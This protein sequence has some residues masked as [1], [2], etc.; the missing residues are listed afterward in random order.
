MIVLVLV[1]G[2]NRFEQTGFRLYPETGLGF[3]VQ[4]KWTVSIPHMNT[5][6][7][8]RQRKEISVKNVVF[9]TIL[10]LYCIVQRLHLLLKCMLSTEFG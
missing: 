7:L 9:V 2:C 8:P 10:A 5:Q 4:N 1:L 6:V 3:L